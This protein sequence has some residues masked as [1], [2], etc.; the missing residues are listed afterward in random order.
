MN[1]FT[2]EE[3]NLICI[4]DTTSRT[5]AMEGINAAMP[6]YEDDDMREIAGNA[7]RKLDAMSDAE[8]SE[9]V[10]VPAYHNEDDEETEGSG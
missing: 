9:Y 1:Y 6:D 3:E 4:Y 7:L 5:A 2:V 8:Y 10:F